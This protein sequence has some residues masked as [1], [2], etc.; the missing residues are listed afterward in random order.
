MDADRP[1]ELPDFTLAKI[2]K[3]DLYTLSV[4]DLAERIEFVEDG[5]RPVRGGARAERFDKVG[6]GEA[7][8]ILIGAYPQIS[9]RSPRLSQAPSPRRQ[10]APASRASAVSASAQAS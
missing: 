6:G 2:G 7:V 8:Q 4:G 3:Q 10:A 5:N 1:R 9:M